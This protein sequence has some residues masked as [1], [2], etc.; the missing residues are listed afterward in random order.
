VKAPARAPGRS[1][2][3]THQSVWFVNQSV[4]TTKSYFYSELTTC[5][6]ADVGPTRTKKYLIWGDLVTVDLVAVTNGFRR[7][8]YRGRSLHTTEGWL[9]ADE[10]TLGATLP[11]RPAT[12]AATGAQVRALRQWRHRRFV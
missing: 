1:G 11:A 9:K 10:L 6:P 3:A 8:T 12:D 7:G 4:A 2:A 5:V